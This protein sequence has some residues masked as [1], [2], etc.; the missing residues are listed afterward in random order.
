MDLKE[1]EILGDQ[2][3]HHWYYRA[4]EAAMRRMLAGRAVRRVLDVGAGSGFFSRRL[5][6][7][8]A[9]SAICVDP[10]YPAEHDETHGGKPIR[11]VHA[12][13]SVQADT[14]LLMDVLEHVD[15]DT[16]LLRFYVDRAAPGTRF[17]ISVPAHSWMWS[18]HD[19]FLEHRRRYTLRQL[20]T[21]ARDAGLTPR[22]GCYYFG[23]TLPIAAAVRLPERLRGSTGEA[24][25]GMQRH[26]PLVNW[27]LRSLSAVERIAFRANRLAGLTAFCLAEK[28]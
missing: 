17:L 8:G 3:N 21:V 2:V 4:K 7:T 10:N 1:S 20:E 28:T 5:L 13:T 22:S 9:E 25:S 11:F 27:A 14:V 15:D 26:S 16:G 12:I 19:V 24:K 23:L 6:E 18:S